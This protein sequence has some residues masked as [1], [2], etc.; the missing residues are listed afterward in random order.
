MERGFLV[1]DFVANLRFDLSFVI[2]MIGEFGDF[3]G[4]C[5]AELGDGSRFI[6]AVSN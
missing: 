2:A 5:C 4:S 1:S 3:L 6:A